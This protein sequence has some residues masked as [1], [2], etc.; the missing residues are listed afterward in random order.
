MEKLL[1][2]DPRAKV[3]VSSGY[4]NQQLDH[5]GISTV[6][7]QRCHGK[8]LSFLLGTQD[9]A[10]GFVTREKRIMNRYAVGRI[11]LLPLPVCGD[12]QCVPCEN[13]PEPPPLLSPNL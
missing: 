2:F 1:L 10:P 8:T 5:A 3:I 12:A 9:L 11:R 13:R 4:I 6:R 7:L